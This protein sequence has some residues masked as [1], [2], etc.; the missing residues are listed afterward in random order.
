MKEVGLYWKFWVYLKGNHIDFIFLQSLPVAVK[1]RIK[2]LK[3]LQ[4][5]YTDLE[6]DF[7]KEVHAL[8]VCETFSFL[9]YFKW[10]LNFL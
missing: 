3:K 10:F 7:Y 9:Y 1:K 2:A 6:A 8:E 5:Q 4:L